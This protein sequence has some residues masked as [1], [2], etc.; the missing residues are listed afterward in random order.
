MFRVSVSNQPESNNWEVVLSGSLED[1][2]EEAYPLPIEE[3]ELE[4]A[5]VEKQYVKF[6]V[7][8]H[9][10]G[11]GGLEYFDIVRTGPLE[12]KS[13]LRRDCSR[14]SGQQCPAL[15]QW[16]PHTNC[17]SATVKWS[18]I[19]TPDQVQQGCSFTKDGLEFSSEA[20]CLSKSNILLP[21]NLT[22]DG[23]VEL[24]T[25][26][27]TLLQCQPWSETE[28]C[29]NTQ[30]ILTEKRKATVG[31]TFSVD[32]K[33]CMGEKGVGIEFVDIS[34]ISTGLNKTGWNL[35]HLSLPNYPVELRKTIKCFRIKKNLCG[36]GSLSFFSK[37]KK[38]NLV[39]TN[40]DGALTMR[41]EYDYCG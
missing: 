33:P 14:P 25:T 39:L 22:A 26:Q 27:A 10:G 11:A 18:D 6:E 35:F 29:D 3:L 21:H 17:V 37:D 38:R 30:H 19:T 12:V 13:E 1:R 32:Y 34:D 36:P 4:V 16:C 15:P 7:V 24:N 31:N 23:V 20:K 28:P 41:K 2:M 5:V 8:S 40:C 9:Y